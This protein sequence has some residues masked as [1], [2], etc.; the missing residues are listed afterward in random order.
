[1][2]RL[3][4][5]A[6]FAIALVVCCQDHSQAQYVT[7]YSPVVAPAPVVTAPVAVVA[8]RPACAAPAHVAYTVARPV[9]YTVARPVAYTVARPVV[10]TVAPVAYARTRYRP[11]LGGTVTRVRY[12]YAPVAVYGY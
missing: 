10:T 11:F 4:L 2:K 9:T 12:R 5:A 3:L 6:A 7:Y 1:M 8:Y